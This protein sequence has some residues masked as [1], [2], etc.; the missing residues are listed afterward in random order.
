M[1]LVSFARQCLRFDLTKGRE[2]REVVGAIERAHIPDQALG[3]LL[4]I[5]LAPRK[6]ISVA[7][8]AMA[9]TAAKLKGTAPVSVGAVSS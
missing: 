5:R 8:A 1:Q 6:G 2:G 7:A 4:R 3:G 9:P